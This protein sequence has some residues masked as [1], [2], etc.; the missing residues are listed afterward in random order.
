M[1]IDILCGDVPPPSEETND[2]KITNPI[3][4]VICTKFLPPLKGTSYELCK[5]GHMM[6]AACGK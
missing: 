5:L 4:A 6:E 1:L 2:K 3:E